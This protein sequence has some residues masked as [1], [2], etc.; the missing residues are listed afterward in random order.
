MQF[1]PNLSVIETRVS[2]ILVHEKTNQKICNVVILT[3][4]NI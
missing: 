4:V 3:P 1:S 2:V